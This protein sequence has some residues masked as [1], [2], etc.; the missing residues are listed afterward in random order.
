MGFFGENGLHTFISAQIR[1]EGIPYT[2]S[3]AGTYS[4]V[5]LGSTAYISSKLTEKSSFT[6]PSVKKVGKSEDSYC[7]WVERST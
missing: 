4:K 3:S 5:E 1:G 2:P 6:L 7:T